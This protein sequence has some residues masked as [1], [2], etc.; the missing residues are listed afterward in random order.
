[1]IRHALLTVLAAA[2]LALAASA[3]AF[4]A[5]PYPLNYKTFD[6]SATSPSTGTAFSGGSLSLATSGTGSLTYADTFANYSND[7]VDGSGTYAS[8]TWTSG[9]TP[10]S[11]G[12]NE[13][14][15][16]WNAVTPPKTWVQV[17][18]QPQLDDGH[19]AK[20]YILGQ[21]SSDDY[22]FHRTSVGGQGDADGFVSIDTLFTKD[23]PAIAYRLRATLYR[24]VGATTSGPTLS[25][26][27]AVASN[28]TNQKGSFPSKTT[29]NGSGKDL[30]VPQYS[31]EIHH[32]DFPQ[33]DNGGEAWCSPTSTSMVVAYW[34]QKT[35]YNYS[36]KPSEYSWVTSVLPSPPH[37]DPWV[38][39]TARAVYDYHYNGAGNW[40]FNAAYAA[41]RG[42]VADVTQLHN[43]AEAEPF[44][45]AGIPLVA[46]VAWNS[47]KLE[48]G[49]KSTN[50][51]LLVIEGFSADGKKVI[52]NDPAS[53]DDAAVKHSYDREQFERAWIPASGGIVYVIRP[54]GWATPSL[55]QNNS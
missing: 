11:F 27:S 7:H 46:S 51:H 48:G 14:V 36:P 47:N 21:W 43:L 30:G 53:I 4:A 54:A 5:Q 22:S 3:P 19:W 42:L 8:G 33:Y 24:K 20:W 45:K 41:S 13:L 37:Q 6:L 29:M 1:M 17:E 15:A 34:T 35:G 39:F 9:V 52:V 26:L 10:L 49:I 2:G 25:R 38:D 16:S 44:I 55:T 18:V 31:Q 28:L 32:G 40:P 50:G 23:H 12:F